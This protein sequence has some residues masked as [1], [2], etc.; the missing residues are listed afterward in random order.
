MAL[1]KKC[2]SCRSAP[3][4]LAAGEVCRR[5]TFAEVDD[6]VY[7]K[8]K[9]PQ[10]QLDLVGIRT[11]SIPRLNSARLSEQTSLRL[12]PASMSYHARVALAPSM[13]ELLRWCQLRRRICRVVRQRTEQGS[14]LS[15]DPLQSTAG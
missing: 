3:K 13:L 9:L 2:G 5:V 15:R 4:E 10:Y 6:L 8:L 7:N 11:V 12:M 1:S 14:W